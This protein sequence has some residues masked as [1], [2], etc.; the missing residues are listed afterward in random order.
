MIVALT[1]TIRK[2]LMSDKKWQRSDLDEFLTN[3]RSKSFAARDAE[4][5]KYQ[6][7]FHKRDNIQED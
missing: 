4:I 3:L 5:A 7:V 1:H 6:K 2:K